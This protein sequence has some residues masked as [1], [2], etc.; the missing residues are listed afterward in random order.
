MY[1]YKE[2]EEYI[3]KIT[4]YCKCGHSVQF[5]SRIPYII[6]SHCGKLIFR[7]KKCEFNYYIKRR[8]INESRAKINC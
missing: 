2:K 1:N 6:C 8:F 7:N 3:N 5:K 4:V